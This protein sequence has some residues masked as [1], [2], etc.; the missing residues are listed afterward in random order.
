MQLVTKHSHHLIS[1]LASTL[2]LNPKT[3]RYYEA[4]GLL[5]QSQRSESGYRLYTQADVE[6]LG[7]IQKAKMLGFSL[8]E[9]SEI[10]KVRE[11]G[12]EPC[13][14]VLTVLETHIH[15]VEAKIQ[16]LQDLRTSLI[17][18]RDLASQAIGSTQAIC[19][20]IEYETTS[21]MEERIS[22]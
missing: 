16:A 7:F 12:V 14:H 1:K 2:G 5:P 15:A 9:I 17:Y 8:E 21:L 18:R 13:T 10:L 20:I 11:D 19:S 22:D 6:R 3:I 4:I